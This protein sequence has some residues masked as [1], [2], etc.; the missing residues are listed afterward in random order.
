[1]TT[2]WLANWAPL[3]VVLAMLVVGLELTLSDFSRQ[4]R[5]WRLVLAATLLQPALLSAVALFALTVFRPAPDLA[6]AML[7]LAV[8][9]GGLISN[10]YTYLVRG[11]VALSVA[12]TALSTL[13][14]PIVIPIV[15]PV[16]AQLSGG[17]V[18]AAGWSPGALVQRLLLTILLPVALGMWLRARWPQRVRAWRRPLGLVT[19]L[20]VAILLVPAVI[21]ALQMSA[22]HLLDMARYAAA[23]TLSAMA[24]AAFLAFMLTSDAKARVAL[25]VEFAVRNIPIAVMLVTA[26]GGSNAAILFLAVYF[27]LDAPMVLVLG[28]TLRR[29]LIARDSPGTAAAGA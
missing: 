3:V 20:V 22:T 28:H 25:S 4:G 11:D 27:V 21:E 12:L 13:L 19:A 5:Q 10:A 14:A 26:N 8:A 29:W 6:L 23:F 15:L 18:E 17:V 2:E 1:M 7:V 24:A 9:P 16:V